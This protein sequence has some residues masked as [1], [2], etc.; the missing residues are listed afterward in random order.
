MVGKE[1]N[2]MKEICDSKNQK[3]II[4]KG[5]FYGCRSRFVTKQVAVPHKGFTIERKKLNKLNKMK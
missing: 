5:S 3:C 4:I 1:N 2:G